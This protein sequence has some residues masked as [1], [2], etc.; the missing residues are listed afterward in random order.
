MVELPA[1]DRS[2][3]L[4]LDRDGV[5][6]HEKQNDY[7]Y[8]Y[9]EFVFYPGALDALK[10]LASRFGRIIIVTN[11]RGVEKQLMTEADLLQLHEQ[12]VAI[13]KE[14]GGRID[15]IYYCTSLNNDH[16]DRKPQAGMALQAKKSFPEIDFRKTF[17]VGNNISD[18]EFGRNAGVKTVF[19]LTTSPLQE[20]PH[21]KIDYHYADLA[22]FANAIES[23]I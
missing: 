22:G 19:V 1:I 18:M 4:F 21:S 15:A 12:M 20:L 5:L 14:H 17:M 16:P 7:I 8:N 9:S 23:Q 6:N 3:T 10:L 13:I 2:W 11:Q